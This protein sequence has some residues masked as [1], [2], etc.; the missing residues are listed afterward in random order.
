M[1]EP[2]HMVL[3][4]VI[5]RLKQEDPTKPVALGFANPHSYRG[6]YND[7]A[8]ELTLG[9]TVGEMLAAA[10]SALGATFQ[11]WKGGD[12]RMSEWT[13]A[14]LVAEEGECGESIGAVLMEFML[15]SEVAR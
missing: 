6:I 15:A 14:W 13:D 12:Y 10:E 11:G 3:G 9:T 4:A 1:I 8:F 7:V 2:M 5:A